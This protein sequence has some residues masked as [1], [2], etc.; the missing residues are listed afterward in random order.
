MRPSVHNNVFY[1][2][3]RGRINE[4]IQYVDDEIAK[5]SELQCP[6]RFA[7]LHYPILR[8]ALDSTE[9]LNRMLEVGI[10]S[11]SVPSL[12]KEGR[13]IIEMADPKNNLANQSKGRC[14]D[15]KAST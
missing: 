6:D 4:A 10:A 3:S 9:W 13:L 1:M 8:R 15:A 5:N 7:L 14:F 12:E 2:V 11:H